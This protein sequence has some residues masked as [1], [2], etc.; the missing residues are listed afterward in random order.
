MGPEFAYD[1]VR[2]YA[3]DHLLLAREIRL[4][5]LTSPPNPS[6]PPAVTLTRKST[7]WQAET[8]LFTLTYFGWVLGKAWRVEVGEGE[9]APGPDGVRPL[10]VVAIGAKTRSK[11]AAV[12]EARKIANAIAEHGWI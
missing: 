11:S 2:R 6:E 12:V 7:R 10:H 3:V 4:A 8:R 5:Y 9:L 1:E